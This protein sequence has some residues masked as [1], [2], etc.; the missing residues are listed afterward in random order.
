MQSYPIPGR[1]ASPET[2]CVTEIF[3]PPGPDTLLPLDKPPRFLHREHHLISG[4]TTIITW[5]C[6]WR[7]GPNKQHYWPTGRC[8]RESQTHTPNAIAG[9]DGNR[10]WGTPKEVHE[11]VHQFW[12][13]S[14]SGG[15]EQGYVSSIRRL[16]HHGPGSCNQ[17]KSSQ[18]PWPGFSVSLCA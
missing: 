13:S 8:G 6:L 12:G 5:C 9:G 1:W 3:P 11:W 15:K 7:G 10:P 14:P 16:G 18:T 4:L 17:R 2:W